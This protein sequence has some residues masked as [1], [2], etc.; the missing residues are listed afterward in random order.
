MVEVCA[1]VVRLELH[2]TQHQAQGQA[3][4]LGQFITVVV[5]VAARWIR[6][7]RFQTGVEDNALAP[8]RKTVGQPLKNKQKILYVLPPFENGNLMPSHSKG[9]IFLKKFTGSKNSLRT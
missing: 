2:D 8:G 1:V 5:D 6:C 4:D 7:R 9:K 3:V